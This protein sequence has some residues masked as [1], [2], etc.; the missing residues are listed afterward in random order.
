MPPE[1][2][3]NPALRAPGLRHHVA[4]TNHP[5]LTLIAALALLAGCSAPAAT[6]TSTAPAPAATSS[7]AFECEE[8]DEHLVDNMFDEEYDFAV[9]GFGAVRSPDHEKVWYIAV[10]A[11]D[12]TNTVTGI[13]G[14]N[15][16]KM[17]AA[18][19]SVDGI[20]REFSSFPDGREEFGL[21]HTDAAAQAAKECIV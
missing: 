12:G 17:P 9:L 3:L 5:A 15:S 20:A 14:S 8:A 1:D 7:P 18:V 6:S 4:M 16:L 21:S 11:T 10:E 2:R 19:R 13:W